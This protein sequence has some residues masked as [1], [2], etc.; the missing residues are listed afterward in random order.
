MSRARA[1][2]RSQLNSAVRTL[3]TTFVVTFAALV[4][5]TLPLEVASPEYVRP[6]D[7]IRMV[8]PGLVFF[9][10]LAVVLLTPLAWPSRIPENVAD[11]ELARAQARNRRTIVFIVVLLVVVFMLA[12]S[13]VV[14]L[15]QPHTGVP[16]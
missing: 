1:N 11:V 10:V 8:A 6:S 5:V 4:A 2:V 13:G 12:M 16:P 14:V 3:V 7:L 9:S 15:L